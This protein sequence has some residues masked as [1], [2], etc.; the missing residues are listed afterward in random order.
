MDYPFLYS[1]Y[2]M[3]DPTRFIPGDRRIFIP[4]LNQKV[5]FLA[6]SFL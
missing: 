4:L 5:G 1:I 2:T 6:T 3:S